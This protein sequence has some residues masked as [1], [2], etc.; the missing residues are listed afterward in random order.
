MGD[1][2]A[3]DFY[4]R[5]LVEAFLAG[6]S[7]EFQTACAALQKLLNEQRSSK[8]F[9]RLGSFWTK[10]PKNFGRNFRTFSSAHRHT[11]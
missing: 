2:Q 3:F 9:V 11:P 1:R 7:I 8:G 6:K 5:Q 10:D 4:R